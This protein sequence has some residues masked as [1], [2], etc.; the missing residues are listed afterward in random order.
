[1][2][3]AEWEAFEEVEG[4]IGWARLDWLI[5]WLVAA[6]L[7]PHLKEPIDWKAVTPPWM[8]DADDD[9][10]LSEEEQ[11]ERRQAVLAKLAAWTGVRQE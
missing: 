9:E 11:D 1:M 4:P 2:D 3:L 7:A 6:T 8:R 5:G 10:E